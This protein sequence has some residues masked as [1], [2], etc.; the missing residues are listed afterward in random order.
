MRRTS[1]ALGRDQ[2]R[3]LGWMGEANG[4]VP[5]SLLTLVAAWVVVALLSRV[6]IP[7]V[8]PAITPTPRPLEML[9]TAALCLP[10]GLSAGLLRDHLAWLT[11]VSPRGT[12]WL[13]LGWLLSVAVS[14]TGL[15]VAS[16]L[17]LPPDVPAVHALAIWLLDLGLAIV[18]V[19]VLGSDFGVVLPFVVTV[20]FS[21]GGLLPFHA[22]LFYN[23]N[24]TY[25]LLA[26]AVATIVIATAC[27]VVSGSRSAR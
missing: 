27:Y 4:V 18:S 1:P 10:A 24:L 14:A 17:L 3:S 12:R 22:N 15:A 16:T 5:R 19:V 25:E 11:A 20:V 7:S 6:G 26:L 8:D 2:I 9:G 21:L 13:R 23:V